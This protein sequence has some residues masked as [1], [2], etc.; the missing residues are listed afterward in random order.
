MELF[1]WLGLSSSTT[2]FEIQ[3]M[4]FC[5]IDL[6]MM[7]FLSARGNSDSDEIFMSGENGAQQKYVYVSEQEP[8]PMNDNG[9]INFLVSYR[10][11][12]ASICDW[13]Q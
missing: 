5:R 8:M 2:G 11:L 1:V 13:I 10:V 7:Y 4:N 9:K 3:R 12:P 6:E